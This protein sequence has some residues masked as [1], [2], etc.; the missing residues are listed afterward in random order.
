MKSACPGGGENWKYYYSTGLP[1]E[2]SANSNT[3]TTFRGGGV[4]GRKIALGERDGLCCVLFLWCF[5]NFG[6]DIFKPEHGAVQCSLPNVAFSSCA[7]CCSEPYHS[8]VTTSPAGPSGKSTLSSAKT[9]TH[10]CAAHGAR[11]G[12]YS[13]T[14][15]DELGQRIDPIWTWPRPL[16]PPSLVGG[17]GEGCARLPR[18]AAAL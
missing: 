8:P 18:A 4:W 9:N 11:G 5:H 7:Q 14:K 2:F 15:V 16:V 3:H 6:K 1:P 10:R 17:V 12:V 13:N